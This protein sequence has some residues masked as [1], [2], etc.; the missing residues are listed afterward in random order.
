MSAQAET[1][2]FMMEKPPPSTCSLSMARTTSSSVMGSALDPLLLCVAQ[3]S[4]QDA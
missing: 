1:L 4:S 3:P 2:T